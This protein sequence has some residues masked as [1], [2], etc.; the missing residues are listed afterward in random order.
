[1]INID[2]EGFIKVLDKTTNFKSYFFYLTFNNRANIIVYENP[3]EI[4]NKLYNNN[5]KLE[6]NK[7]TLS[8]YYSYMKQIKNEF[9]QHQI[10]SKEVI[11]SFSTEFNQLM[12][13]IYGLEKWKSLYSNIISEMLKEHFKDNKNFISFIHT[14][15]SQGIRI[16]NHTLVYP[17]KYNKSTGIYELYNYIPD[18]DLEKLKIEFNTFSRKLVEKNRNTIKTL[19]VKPKYKQYLQHF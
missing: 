1:M 9:V 4:K 18:E 14:F 12:I 10:K 13:D 19:K 5:L 15:D 17:Y 8:L 3:Q 2:E 7:S 16:H 6:H 11:M